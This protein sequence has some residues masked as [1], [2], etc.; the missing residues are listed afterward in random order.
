MHM[1]AG[2]SSNGVSGSPGGPSESPL[3]V[4]VRAV[5]S[6]WWLVILVTLAAVAGSLFILSNRNPEYSATAQIQITPLPAFNDTFVGLDVIRDSGDGPRTAQTAAALL[7]SSGAAAAVARELGPPWT[8]GSVAQAVSVEPQGESNVLGVTATASDPES[9]A[10]LANEFAGSAVAIRYRRLERQLRGRIAQLQARRRNL[11]QGDERG[12][13]VDQIADLE[14]IRAARRDPSLAVLQQA[15]VPG[16][17]TGTADWLLVVLAALA[18]LALGMVAAT[19]LGLLNRQIR[20]EEELLRLY[21]LPVLT[22]VPPLKRGLRRRGS[23][24]PTEMPPAAREAFRTLR[25]QLEQQG[26]AHRSVMLAS[27]SSGDGKTTASANLATALVDADYSVIL[28]DFDL[29]KPELS[30]IVGVRPTHG[31]SSMLTSDAE[32]LDLLVRSPIAPGLT[33]LAAVEGDSV[34]LEAL[35]RRLPA[36]LAEAKEMADFVVLDTA[37]LGEVSDA[38]RVAAQIDDIVLV[39]RP[40]HTNRH[41]F[42]QVRD[43]LERAGARPSGLLL[44][45]QTTR[46]S[47]TYYTYGSGSRAGV[48]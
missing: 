22:R 4:L 2:S 34:F 19:M 8:R 41:N 35:I 29:R 30:G 16:A 18:G 46:S 6:H 24:S 12:A 3:T 45:G 37:P 26:G 47:H 5:R 23:V 36:I 10:A 44:T 17:P 21:P 11:P 25:A 40:G 28:V 9:A 20:D 14:A 27:A 48:R 43:L 15:L 39:A 13:V 32:L 33:L 38:L 1:N 31:L 7:E 42:E